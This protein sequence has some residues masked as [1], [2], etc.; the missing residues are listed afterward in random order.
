MRRIVGD[1]SEWMKW[2]IVLCGIVVVG[3][4]GFTALDTYDEAACR[5]NPQV[6]GSRT[7]PNDAY[8]PNPFAKDIPGNTRT[9]EVDILETCDG[10]L[11]W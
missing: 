10:F 4:V 1:V 3:A 11:P 2:L 7:V 8:N 6:V 9:I 5:E